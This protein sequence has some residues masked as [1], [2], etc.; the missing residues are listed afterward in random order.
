MLK[1]IKL[2]CVINIVLVLA[3]SIFACKKASVDEKSVLPTEVVAENMTERKTEKIKIVATIFPIYDIVRE[4]VPE[5]RC[6]V[7]LLLDSGI[8]IHNFQPTAKDITTI[9]DSDLFIYIGGESDSWVQKVIDTSQNKN[10]NAVNLMEEISDFVK[11]EEIVE[12]M[13]HEHEHESEEGH[14]EGHEE[15]HEEHEHEAENDEHIWLSLRNIKAIT[16]VIADKLIELDKDNKEVVLEKAES[17]QGKVDDLDKR[18]KEVV[19]NASVK[20]LLFADRFPF[21]YLVDDYKLSYFAAFSGC[22]AEVEASFETVAFLAKKIDELNL[23]HISAL[24][25]SHHKIPETVKNT[26]EKK[27]QDIIYFDSMEGITDIEDRE[28][29]NYLKI[30]EKN[31]NSLEK[32]LN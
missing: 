7:T 1:K 13:E 27:D 16:D 3:A 29:V 30:M 31:L 23:R 25:G 19:D 26:T 22:S 12:G 18:Y 28:E 4:L 21:R 14:E 11:K 20:T 17:F 2:F 32:A 5:D 15:E 24:T 9:A 8:D 6:E 10:L